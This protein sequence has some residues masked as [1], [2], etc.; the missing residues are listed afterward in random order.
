ME[1]LNKLTIRGFKSIQNL[2]DFE[3][4]QLNIIV[5]ANGA[6]KSNLISFFRLLRFF[7][8]DRL[9]QYIIS[10]GGVDDFL[11]NGPKITDKMFF[12]THFGCRGYRF[13]LTPTS[14]GTCAVENE[15]RYYDFSRYGWWSLGSSPNGSS[16]MVAEIKNNATDAQYSRPVYDT[17]M[18]WQ[19]YHF[20]DTSNTAGMRRYDILENWEKLSADASNIAPFLLK[21]RKDWPDSYQRIV[22]AIRTVLP[23]FDDFALT[24]Q[25]FGEQIK[26]RLSWRQ[27]G[28]DYPMQPYHLSDGSMRFICLATA[29]LQPEPPSMIIIDEPELGLHPEAIAILA[30][31]IEFASKH[32]QVVIATQSPLLLNFFSL[33]DIIVTKRQNGSS[34]FTRL[35]KE[36]FS[37]WLDDFNVGE[38]WAKNVLEGGATHE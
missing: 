5:G 23:Y 24:P 20:H 6:G 35:K 32:T 4:R 1:I 8:E 16:R 33:D 10:N 9:N 26:V 28:S 22:D 30:E 7:V 31:L 19:L 29:L 3:L 14:E 38:L 17:I 18:S 37:H 15:S 13:S 36:D 12:E 11:Y 27:K 25:T 21:M 2:E 34:F